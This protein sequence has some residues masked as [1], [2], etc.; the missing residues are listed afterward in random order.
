[1]SSAPFRLAPLD[2]AYDRT[3]FNSGS[4]LLDR[5]LREQVTQDVRRRVAACFVALADGPR[6][7]GFYTLASASLL[8]VDL[9]TSIGKRLP[10]Y[11]TVPAVRMGRLAVDQAFKGQGLGGALL[12]DA[13]DRAAR[14]EI[15]AYALMVDAKDEVAAAFYQHHGFIAL[16]DSPLT[17]FLPLATA[18]ASRETDNQGRH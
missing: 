18:L 4:E 2:V 8:L 1:M 13:L 16:H 7:A 15:A 3:V 6:I 10:R 5:Y 9:P 11:P 12:A 17:L 14:S